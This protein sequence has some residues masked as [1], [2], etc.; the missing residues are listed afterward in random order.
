MVFPLGLWHIS[1]LDRRPS[2][3]PICPAAAGT[4][5]G[6]LTAAIAHQPGRDRF[7]PSTTASA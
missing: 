7:W 6:P 5:A 3:A 4:R 1:R 2:E